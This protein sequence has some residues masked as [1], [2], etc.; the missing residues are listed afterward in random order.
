M[1][2]LQHLVSLLHPPA[3]KKRNKQRILLN[4]TTNFA[5]GY[6]HISCYGSVQ[7]LQVF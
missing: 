1:G 6:S 7:K 4:F 2:R 3:L 5:N